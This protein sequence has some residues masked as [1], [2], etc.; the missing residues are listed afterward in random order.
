MDRRTFV[1]STGAAA[2]GVAAVGS[3][4]IQM[5]ATGS[6]AAATVHEVKMLNKGADGP[7]VFEPSFVKMAMGDSI[8]FIPTDKGHFMQNIEGGLPEGVPDFVSKIN[9]EFTFT[10]TVEGVYAIKCKPH[11]PMGMVMAFQVGAPTNLE[12][13]KALKLNKKGTERLMAALAQVAM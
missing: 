4:G 11:L 3:I 8:K 7:M 5:F 13:I 10:P 9:E 6:A 1:K 2:L 12:A